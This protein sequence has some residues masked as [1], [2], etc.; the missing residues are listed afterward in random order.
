MLEKILKENEN[1][2]PDGFSTKLTWIFIL[3]LKNFQPSGRKFQIANELDFLLR[4]NY[5]KRNP[6]KI[7]LE[8]LIIKFGKCLSEF[9]TRTYQSFSGLIG[10]ELIEVLDKAFCQIFCFCF[11][12]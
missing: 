6:E 2:L 12:F 3:C 1:S 11:P 4:K 8:V 5:I 7:F 10:R 9:W